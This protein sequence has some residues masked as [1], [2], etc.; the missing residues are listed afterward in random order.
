MTPHGQRHIDAAK[1]DGRWGAAYA[2]ICN[3]TEASIPDDLLAAINAN[4]PRAQNAPVAQSAESFCAG[5]SHQQHEDGRGRA[6]KIAALVAMLAR[7][8]TIV[9]KTSR[10]K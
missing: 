10:R 3:V 7:G 4:P 2:P 8:E 9:A 5:V 1:A 6:S